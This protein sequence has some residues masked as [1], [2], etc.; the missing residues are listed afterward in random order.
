MNYAKGD[1]NVIDGSSNR[2]KGDSNYVV[3]SLKDLRIFA[4]ERH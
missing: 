2:V 1:S 4:R 3:N